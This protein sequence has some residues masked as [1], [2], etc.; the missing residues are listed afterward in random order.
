MESNTQP[1][2]EKSLCLLEKNQYTFNVESEFT[3][4]EIK[5]WV[6]LLFDVKGYV[7]TWGGG[8]NPSGCSAHP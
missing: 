1:L 2:Q 6:E 4:T 7:S 8:G 5:H 3:E